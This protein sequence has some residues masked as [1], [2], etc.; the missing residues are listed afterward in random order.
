MTIADVTSGTLL[1]GGAS[2][3]LSVII[4]NRCESDD[5]RYVSC[6]LLGTTVPQGMLSLEDHMWHK[7]LD[8]RLLCVG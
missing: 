3:D 4:A 2:G 7:L 5:G 6:A 1:V 8:V